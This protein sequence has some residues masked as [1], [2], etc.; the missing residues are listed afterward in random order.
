MQSIFTIKKCHLQLLFQKKK[1]F[2]FLHTQSGEVNE[3]HKKIKALVLCPNTPK[4]LV[5]DTTKFKGGMKY[6]IVTKVLWMYYLLFVLMDFY[7]STTQKEDWE[8]DMQ[9]RT[10]RDKEGKNVVGG[11]EEKEK[12]T[13]SI[14]LKKKPGW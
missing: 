6:E 11:V 9:R 13:S 8:R 3:N 5:K 10:K 14:S 12:S 1:D 7:V 4:L 2:F